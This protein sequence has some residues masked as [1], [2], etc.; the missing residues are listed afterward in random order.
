MKSV[1][2]VSILV[3]DDIIKEGTEA[4]LKVLVE[5]MVAKEQNADYK[6]INFNL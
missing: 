4:G 2:F 1:W 3:H 6:F 5:I